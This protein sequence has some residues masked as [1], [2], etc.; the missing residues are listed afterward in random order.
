MLHIMCKSQKYRPTSSE[1]PG[2]TPATYPPL[3][4]TSPTRLLTPTLYLTFYTSSPTT[5]R[6]SSYHL[7]PTVTISMQ[8]YLQMSTW[9]WL[10]LCLRASLQP[11][12]LNTIILVS[13]SQPTS[14][15]NHNEIIMSVL[16]TA[17]LFSDH[18]Y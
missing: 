11:L 6:Q 15:H 4:T 12:I 5:Y 17:P 18:A 7:L 14:A 9:L 1:S 16:T 8:M 13:A 10:Q 3:A 2:V